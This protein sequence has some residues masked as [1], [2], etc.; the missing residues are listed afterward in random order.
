MEID[1]EWD[2]FDE[3]LK[4]ALEEAK[5]SGKKLILLH[6]KCILLR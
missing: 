1:V 6:Q 2:K 5:A 3:I 4:T